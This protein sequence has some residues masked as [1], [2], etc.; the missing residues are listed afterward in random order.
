[1]QSADNDLP[2][3]IMTVSLVSSAR[4]PR[5]GSS[6]YLVV[7]LHGFCV[8]FYYWW[9]CCMT[10]VFTSIIGEAAAWLLC[11]L[12]LLVKLLH[13]FC[14]YCQC[15]AFG[16]SMVLHLC[17]L[18]VHRFW[19]FYGVASVSTASVFWYFYGVASVS[20]ASV[21]WYF[22]GVAS[23]S[24]SCDGDGSLVTYYC[25]MNSCLFLNKFM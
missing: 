16:T 17:L 15:M 14:I 4:L 8:Y 22:Y 6:P 7:L 3:V 24:T 23:V 18:P 1:M 9:S 10:S 25:L 12:L 20:T 13:G 21:F 11:L 19:Y 5:L 2:W